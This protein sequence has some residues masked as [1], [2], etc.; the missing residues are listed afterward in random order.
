M[1]PSSLDVF[2]CAH[3]TAYTSAEIDIK[4]GICLISVYFTCD[5]VRHWS[6]GDGFCCEG[7]FTESTAQMNSNIR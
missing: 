2:G 4:L 1:T 6:F 5:I 7:G 3:V